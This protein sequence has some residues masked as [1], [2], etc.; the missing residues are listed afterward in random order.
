MK[1]ITVISIYLLLVVFTSCEKVQQ[2]DLTNNLSYESFTKYVSSSFSDKAA[3]NDIL[4]FIHS[5]KPNKKIESEKSKKIKIESY[6]K[7]KELFIGNDNKIY[8]YLIE[9]PEEIDNYI[10]ITSSQNFY[11]IY[12]KINTVAD[13]EMY[14]NEVMNNSLLSNNEKVL[15]SLFIAESN[16]NS[17]KGFW[18]CVKRYAKLAEITGGTL[19]LTLYEN[20]PE[21][22]TKYAQTALKNM[23]PEY[24]C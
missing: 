11:D 17:Q 1:K 12:S 19:F 18:S 6:L 7:E 21:A 8:D 10:K 16:Q 15:L 4:L 13:K 23:G 14:Y 3:L 20:D 22:A 24:D 2:K 5:D 9:N